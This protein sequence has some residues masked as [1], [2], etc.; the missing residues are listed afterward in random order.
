MDRIE[1]DRARGLR[2]EHSWHVFGA[3]SDYIFISHNSAARLLPIVEQAERVGRTFGNDAL[4][5][6]DTS[7]QIQAIFQESWLASMELPK[8]ID[9]YA[10]VLTPGIAQRLGRRPNKRFVAEGLY[11]I[12]LLFSAVD[13]DHLSSV[14]DIFQR[15]KDR[16][17]GH[18]QSAAT[19]QSNRNEQPY[20]Q[21][22]VGL[23]SPIRTDQDD[24]GELIGLRKRLRESVPMVDSE[25]W[26]K[27]RGV[28]T[29]PSATLAKYREQG[30]L[31]SVR[32]GRNYLYPRF[33]FTQDAAPLD[34]IADIL[35][36]VPEDARGWPLLSWFEAPSTLLDGRKPS[37]VLAKDPAAVRT[38]A[39]DFYADD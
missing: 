17:L 25:Q 8:D 26:G 28:T 15:L 20:V 32:E 22:S 35:K 12:D 1:R 29:N 36:V 21:G 30:R 6:I 37:E 39:A 10:F 24:V 11:E 16:L 31:F 19:P 23:R 27:W 18:S 5:L 34:A 33:Q 7:E 4:M 3:P 14:E 38:A 2:P 9:L 13:L